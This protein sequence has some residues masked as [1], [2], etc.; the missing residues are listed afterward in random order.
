MSGKTPPPVDAGP[1]AGMPAG[2]EDAPVE[3]GPSQEAAP[4]KPTAET[5]APNRAEPQSLPWAK[6]APPSTEALQEPVPD[7]EQ[8][9]SVEPAPANP[10]TTGRSELT[11]F[12][13]RERTRVN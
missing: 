13:D 3:A 5:E 11:L 8:S 12:S 1:A 10:R 2:A 7:G 9:D 4:G 6:P